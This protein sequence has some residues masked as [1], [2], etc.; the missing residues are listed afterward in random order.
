MC[1]ACFLCLKLFHF[2]Q[3]VPLNVGSGVITITDLCLSYPKHTIAFSVVEALD[4]NLDLIDKVEL[5][6]TVKGTFYVL[7]HRGMKMHSSLHSILN[8]VT[9]NSFLEIRYVATSLHLIL[10]Y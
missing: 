7:D 10:L 6:S 2:F 1:L 3:I 9:S 8:V 4:V 5:G